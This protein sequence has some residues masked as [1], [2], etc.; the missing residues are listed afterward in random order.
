[1]PFGIENDLG[2]RAPYFSIAYIQDIFRPPSDRQRGFSEHNTTPKTLCM[3][4]GYDIQPDHRL[5]VRGL[6]SLGFLAGSAG[7]T[8]CRALLAI[9]VVFK[10]KLISTPLTHTGGNR[11]LF[12]SREQKRA[13]R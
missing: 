9:K 5:H 1:M 2:V 4:A 12:P 11:T 3:W 6:R 10:S 7:Y 13:R 8:Y